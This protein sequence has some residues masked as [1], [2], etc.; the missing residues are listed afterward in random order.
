MR[1]DADLVVAQVD[2]AC[3]MRALRLR[4]V[5][6]GDTTNRRGAARLRLGDIDLIAELIKLKRPTFDPAAQPQM[7][8]VRTEGFCVNYRD[9]AIAAGATHH[10][11]GVIIGSEFVGVVEEIGNAVP[12]LHPGQRVIA[13]MQWPVPRCVDA[14]PGVP[15]NATSSEYLILHWASLAPV[16]ATM[17]NASAAGF[18]LSA[19]TAF[20]MVRRAEIAPG[21]TVL[22]TAGGSNTALA[23][24]QASAARG[25]KVTVTTSR[26][27]LEEF[28]LSLGA[29][30]VIYLDSGRG[31]LA[32][33]ADAAR[34]TGGFQVVLDPFADAHLPSLVRAT[35]FFGR[36]V[37]C[38]V[39]DQ[40]WPLP[41]N[42]HTAPAH[43]PELLGML[44]AKNIRLTGNCLGLRADLDA[45]I[46]AY[47][48]GI[49]RPIIHGVFHTETLQDF[50]DLSFL[51]SNRVGKAVY[52]Y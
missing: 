14:F 33:L 21:E 22:V 42:R 52:L 7:V 24:I 6:P 9:M 15:T 37:T 47:L 44:I 28:L 5:E 43:L 26:M 4:R 32:A 23:L 36:Y 13:D 34:P 45:A 27:E 20:S 38:G 29:Q 48:A 3:E 31:D 2:D 10:Q 46:G 25:A 51:P 40:G 11:S 17:P 12:D 8:L 41:A 19:Q 18:T 16:P 50:V 35:A 30:R 39:A 49:Y 1:R